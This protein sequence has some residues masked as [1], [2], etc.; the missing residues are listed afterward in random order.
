MQRLLEELRRLPGIGAKTAERLAYHLL[1][2][3]KEEVLALAEA[4]RTVRERTTPCSICGHLDESDPCA[5]CGDP[6]RET[7]LL[8][9][10]EESK[11]LYSIER[12]GEFHGRYHVLG[13]RVAPLEGRSAED[14][15]LLALRRR[16]ESGTVR[17]VI[18][19]TNADVEGDTTALAVKRALEGA[20]PVRVTRLARG[21]PMGS[22]IEFAG[23]GVLK[24]AMALRQELP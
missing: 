1:R 11:D 18:L 14:L 2:R 17:E 23:A 10:V 24:E 15:N 6:A 22:S 12:L 5:I 4:I 19:A 21:L 3:P 13:G 20:G 9:I 7:S 16:V 8:C